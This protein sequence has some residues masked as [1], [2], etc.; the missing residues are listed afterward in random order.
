MQS[1][2]QPFLTESSRKSAFL[3]SPGDRL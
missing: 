2:H 1:M 3:A